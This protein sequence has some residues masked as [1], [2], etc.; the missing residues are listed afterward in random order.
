MYVHV[1][2][3]ASVHV[4]IICVYVSVHMRTCACMHACACMYVKKTWVTAEAKM[5]G[6]LGT[7]DICMYDLHIHTRVCMHVC[8][9]ACWANSQRTPRCRDYWEAKKQHTHLPI[10]VC[11][12][13]CVCVCVCVWVCICLCL[14]LCICMRI[15]ICIRIIKMRWCLRY[16]RRKST[17]TCLYVLVYMHVHV[18]VYAYVYARMYTN[19]RMAMPRKSTQTCIYVSCACI[20]IYAGILAYIHTYGK[21]LNYTCLLAH[22]HTHTYTHTHTHTHTHI[23]I[24]I[25]QIG[26]QKV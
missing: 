19:V 17:H 7:P 15:Q 25:S 12:Y 1:Y 14:C 11:V 5:S 8:V 13:V 3:Q 20:S 2:I 4:S 22:T 6:L 18:Y 10:C 24:Y 23:Y 16:L 21:L 9:Y 26:I